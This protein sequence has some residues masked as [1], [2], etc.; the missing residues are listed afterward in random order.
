M[1]GA[2]AVRTVQLRQQVLDAESRADLVDCF[3]QHGVNR[4]NVARCVG[5]RQ[6]DELHMASRSSAMPLAC[7][8]RAEERRSGTV[9]LHQQL[10]QGSTAR[11]FRHRIRGPRAK[12]PPMTGNMAVWAA[13]A[14]D[15]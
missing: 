8:C 12:L 6:C 7:T 1:G 3:A 11:V 2:C 9:P 10:H 15:H 5:G 14:A 4:L 13:A